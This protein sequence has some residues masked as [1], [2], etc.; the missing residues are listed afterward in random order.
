MTAKTEI[1]VP[2]DT[3]CAIARQDRK[4]DMV[5]ILN[6]LG[7]G[8]LFLPTPSSLVNR[9]IGLRAFAHHFTGPGK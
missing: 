5:E 1:H 2:V 6:L 4:M 7:G 9:T 3:Q 8:S